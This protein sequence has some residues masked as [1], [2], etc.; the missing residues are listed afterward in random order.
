MSLIPLNG[1]SQTLFKTCLGL[2]AKLSLGPS[3]IKATT[4]LTARLAGIPNNFAF[5]IGHVGDKMHQVFDR[6]LK[7]SANINGIGFVVSFGRQGDG[8]STIL[9]IKKLAGRRAV[10]PNGHSWYATRLSIFLG[11]N[12]LT[13]QSWDDMRCLQIKVI[14]GAVEAGDRPGPAPKASFWRYHKEHWFPLDSHP[15]D[16]PL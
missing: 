5:K 11:L 6:N 15:K 1:L 14:P 8:F 2:E 13:N 10:T 4:G 16:S 12:E 9:Y 3:G 7:A